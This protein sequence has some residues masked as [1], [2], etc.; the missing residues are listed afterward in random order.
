MSA[1]KQ[2]YNAIAAPGDDD[3]DHSASNSH[4]E[5]TPLRDRSGVDRVRD[6]EFRRYLRTHLAYILC[7]LIGLVL[8]IIFFLALLL[9]GE[10]F[11]LPSGV[12]LDRPI[13][14]GISAGALHEGLAKCRG[15]QTPRKAN[16]PKEDRTNPRSKRAQPV[17]LKNAVVWD[18]QGE[19]LEGVDILMENG[20]IKCVGT[21]IQHSVAKVIDVKGHIVSPGLVDMHS[22]LGLFPWPL[23]LGNHDVNEETSPLTPYVRALDAFNPSD[24]SIRIVAAGG[25][26]TALVL[27]GSG[28]LMGGEA[29]AFKLRNLPTNSNDDMLVQ[30][31][32]DEEFETKQRYLKMACGENPK[33]VYGRFRNEMPASRLGEAYLFRQG[34]SD[35]RRLMHEQDD[36]CNAA[37]IVSDGNTVARLDTRFP[38]NI[39]LEPLVALL[40]GNALLNVHCYESYDIEAMIRHA[41]EFNFTIAAFHHALDAYRIPEILKRA[42]NNITIATFADNWGFKKEAFQGTPLAPKILVDAGIPVALKTDH[43][44]VNAQ[45]LIFEAAKANHYGLSPQE[46]IKTVTSV[47][48]AAIGLGHRIGS[49]RVGYDADVVIWDR[50]PLELGAAPLQVFVDGE[51]LLEERPIPI[52]VEKKEKSAQ[53]QTLTT[54]GLNIK[55]GTKN[56]VLKNVRH[57]LLN[58]KDVND[59]DSN[60]VVVQNGKVVCTGTDCEQFST[61]SVTGEPMSEVDVQG[62]YVIPGLIAVGSKL[63]LVEIPSEESTS[64]G[65]A[66]A[67]ASHDA[68]IVVEALDGIKLGTRHLEEAYKGGV[69]TAITAPISNNVVA[70]ISTA[71]KTGADSLLSD[72]ALVSPAVALHLQ[73]GNSVKSESF[74]T[75]SSQIAFIR[76]ILIENKDKSNYYGKAARGEIPTIIAVNN[77]DEIASIIRLKKYFPRARFAILGGAEAHLVAEHLAEANI[78]VIL[79]PTLCTPDQF[80]SV[81]CLTG[82]P[83]TNGTAAHVLHR[84][85]VKIALG[86]KNDG[87]ARNL[88]WDAGWLSATSLP[89]ESSEDAFISETEAIRFV[90][91]NLQEIFGVWDT[92]ILDSN[93]DFVVWSGSPLELHSRPLMIHSANTGVH[94]LV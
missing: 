15:I 1:T 72:G 2:G 48:A 25:V 75:I 27:P 33:K 64:D 53:V 57:V 4:T 80:E 62:G 71:F 93:Q 50:P 87:D 41:N 7:S 73:I 74:P 12:R 61:A 49:L 35:A 82:A 26:T 76:H 88:A 59:G 19:V 36:W 58:N 47:P 28:N 85:G 89:F 52:A 24:I 79:R 23:L 45:H 34:F 10:N 81:H 84:H 14:P 63:G 21:A 16:V 3:N 37:N 9:P 56:F 65:T 67:S 17:L 77:K 6:F 8:V 69:L 20:V 91:S 22:H 43:P 94:V 32:I 68:N 31:G 70:G 60:T 83:L 54:K 92:N 55:E 5:E 30:A 11:P 46:A 39:Q 44:V 13:K 38:E 40:R 90:T 29:Y 18:G 51:P 86:V 66:R 42:R 78:A